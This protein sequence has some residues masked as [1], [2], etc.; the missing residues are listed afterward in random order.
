MVASRHNK[1]TASLPVTFDRSK[2]LYLNLQ[3]RRT[4]ELDTVWKSPSTWLLHTSTTPNDIFWIGFGVIPSSPYSPPAMLWPKKQSFPP[5]CSKFIFVRGGRGGV[6]TFTNIT[7]KVPTILT[8]TVL[9]KIFMQIEKK[10]LKKINNWKK[11]G[12]CFFCFYFTSMKFIFE[13]RV[14]FGFLYFT[15]CNER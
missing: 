15:I 10:K 6:A 3:L 9:S 12:D 5:I 7:E 2:T 14:P 1:K 8:S 4:T 13:I 11:A